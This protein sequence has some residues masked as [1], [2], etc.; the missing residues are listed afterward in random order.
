MALNSPQLPYSLTTHDVLSLSILLTISYL[1]VRYL[2]R[3]SK[4]KHYPPGPPQ[5][6]LLGNLRDMPTTV[7]WEK[8]AKYRQEYGE[9]TYMRAFGNGILLLNTI[10]AVNDL[11]DRRARIYSNRPRTILAGEIA[12]LKKAMP[13]VEYNDRYKLMR[14]MTN[15]ALNR[16]TVESY[17]ES[18]HDILRLFLNGIFYEPSELQEHSRRN[19][20]RHVLRFVYGLGGE[21]YASDVKAFLLRIAVVSLPGAYIVDFLPWLRYLPSWLPFTEFQVLGKKC[22]DEVLAFINRPFNYVKK[23]LDNSSATE[24]MV[25]DLLKNLPALATKGTFFPEK[26]EDV[27]KWTAGSM[28]AAGQETTDAATMSFFVA[29]ALHPDVQAQAQAEI[30]ELASG[31][32]LIS[33]HDMDR[34]PYVQAMVKEVLRWRISVPQAEFLCIIIGYLIPS[35]TV[36][37]PNVWAISRSVDKPEEFLPERFLT[38]DPPLDPSDY[39]FGFG[40][41]VCPGKYFA[42]SFIPIIMAN[43]LLYYNIREPSTLSD[44][45]VG[46]RD[47]KYTTSL[48]RY[49]HRCFDASL[50][51]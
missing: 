22:H 12:G 28:L 38:I 15:G 4:Q 44:G 21:M 32:E 10:E 27:L 39:I 43:I 23:Q 11:F 42:E 36:I 20:I 14:K 9:L 26:V 13:F 46:P 40:R 25:A 45:L 3:Y 18:Q 33:I 34:L 19:V 48:V 17:Q 5:H 37:F 41:R 24:C 49:G 1:F 31:A 7:N 47:V 29:M 50:G 16:R 51:G 35:G 2:S 6:W 30:D 8:L